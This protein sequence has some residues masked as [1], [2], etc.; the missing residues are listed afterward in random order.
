MP[1][2][3]TA[4]TFLGIWYPVSLYS[5]T[6]SIF[7][8]GIATTLYNLNNAIGSYVWGD[9][10]DRTKRRLEYGILLPSLLSLSAYLMNGQ[11]N[12]GLIGYSLA[13]F[14][15]ALNSPLYSLILLENYSFEDV[16][17]INSRLSQLTLIGNATGSI[18][19][20]FVS[21]SVFPLLLCLTSIPLSVIA[22]LGSKGKVNI[23]KPSRTRS[24]RELSGAL[25]SFASFNFSA[26]IF[27]TAYVPFN[28]LMG[29]PESIIYVSYFLLYLADEGVYY[30][31]GKWTN[32]REVF[33]MS[34]SIAGRA[35]LVLT[36]SV[37]LKLGIRSGEY[38]VPVFMIFGSFYPLFGTSFFSFMF[39][40]LK[41]NR[42]SI[43]GIFNAVEDIANIGGSSVVSFL[44]NDLGLDY[45]VAFY[46]F[47]LSAV[48][49]YS[50]ISKRLNSPSSSY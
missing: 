19:A 13:G 33:F 30:L 16:P 6:K 29:N 42:G 2:L 40:N 45:L 11:L 21:S 15:S 32:N 50:F 10:L 36:V 48:T 4:T 39:R 3:V 18:S 41:K 31:A 20:I 14:T 44:G 12:E 27:F 7:L 25:L 38:S 1:L 49:L 34:F 47:V 43:I 8:L 26:E 23:D 17:K 37:L 22:L 46:S 5:E 28:Y 24:I 9:L 35:L